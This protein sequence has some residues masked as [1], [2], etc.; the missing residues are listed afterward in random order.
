M[1][2]AA[3]EVDTTA[4]Q[5][6]KEEHIERLQKERFDCEKIARQ[7][8]IFVMGHELVPAWRTAPF[9]SMRDAVSSQDIGDGF[10]AKLD[11]QF[12]EF[13]CDLEVAPVS[14]FACQSHDEPFNFLVGTGT[15]AM[16]M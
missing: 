7:N 6:N 16:P 2:G 10:V 9:G 1:L 3:C 14:I 15:T 11:A 12:G 8:L 5:L 13:A 4:A